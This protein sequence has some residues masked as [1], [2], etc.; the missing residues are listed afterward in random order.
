MKKLSLFVT[1]VLI[2]L[3]TSI[4]YA[5]KL[6]VNISGIQVD[7]GRVLVGAFRKTD[8]FL[9]GN[10]FKKVLLKSTF[11]HGKTTFKLKDGEYAI[12]IFQDKNNNQVLD[13][14]FLGIPKE[15]YGFSGRS[16]LGKPS[17]KDA[18]IKVKSN[19]SIIIYL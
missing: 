8:Q 13:K 18:S 17:F 14:N 5:N 1:L 7:N 15:K 19:I 3:S 4:I 11:T 6:T 16:V 12:G 9:Y 10:P 2:T